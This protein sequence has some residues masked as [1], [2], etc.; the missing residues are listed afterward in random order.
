[1]LMYRLDTLDIPQLKG[2]LPITAA[3]Q[4][5]SGEQSYKLRM[6]FKNDSVVCSHW[7]T[8]RA[9][10]THTP[11]E[12]CADLTVKGSCISLGLDVEHYKCTITKTN[13]VKLC[14]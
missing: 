6:T 10:P 14:D 4:M 12:F 3:L 9:I 1:M 8:P 11:I 7:P 5:D 2:N 13:I